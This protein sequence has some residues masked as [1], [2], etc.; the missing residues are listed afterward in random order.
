MD[1]QETLRFF[2]KKISP[3]EYGS[4]ILSTLEKPSWEWERVSK[5]IPSI[6]DI[7]DFF[8]EELLNLLYDMGSIDLNEKN[9]LKS[10]SYVINRNYEGLNQ[11]INQLSVEHIDMLIQCANENQKYEIQTML[12]DYKY[13]HNLFQKKE[14]ELI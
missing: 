14:L 5:P 4:I 8:S 7:L 3:G 10:I 6:N 9:V 1:W 2:H 11:C 13:K 12:M